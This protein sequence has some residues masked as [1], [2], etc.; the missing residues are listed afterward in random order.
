MG[1][2]GSS[3]V[4]GRAELVSIFRRDFVRRAS[5]GMDLLRGL[6]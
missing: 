3:V 5:L 4:F 2:K 6:R 1:V